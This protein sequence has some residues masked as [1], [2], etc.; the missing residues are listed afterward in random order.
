MSGVIAIVGVGL[1]GGSVA[2]SVRLLREAHT[3]VGIGLSHAELEPALQTGLIDEAYSLSQLSPI[4]ANLVVACTPIS[5]IV[6]TLARVAEFV[7]ESAL[8]TDVGSTK[9]QILEM[10]SGYSWADRF[11]GAHPLAGSE[12]SG[13]G[14][15][16]GELFQNRVCILTP[17]NKNPQSYLSRCAEF[18]KSLGCRIEYLD[19]E[20]HDLILARTSH[21]PHIGAAIMASLVNPSERVFT[22]GGWRD[23]TRIASGNPEL[24]QGILMSNA[25]A[26]QQALEQFIYILEEYRSALACADHARLY[27]LLLEGK[28]A[29]DDLGS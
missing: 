23:T 24:W 12:K 26:I 16:N 4:P 6:S 11:V 22:A 14:A 27:K 10:A 15:S 2:K 13:V 18:W 25:S 5:E 7:P 19:P 21:V 3:I 1:M 17:T 8:F 28:V 20:T 29:R 9:A